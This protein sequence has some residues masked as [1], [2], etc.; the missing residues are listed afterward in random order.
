[1]FQNFRLGSYFVIILVGKVLVG[2][3]TGCNRYRDE[4]L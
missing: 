4:Q 2:V 1:M 3:Q